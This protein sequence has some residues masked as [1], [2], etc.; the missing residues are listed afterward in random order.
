MGQIGDQVDLESS[1]GYLLKEAASALRQSMETEL[2]PLGLNISQ[3]ACLELLAQR[4]GLSSSEL[5]RG[6][7]ITRQSMSTLLQLLERDGLVSRADIAPAGR[8]L[9][10]ELTPMGRQLLAFASSRVRGVEEAMLAGLAD[11]DRAHL[12]ELLSSCVRSLRA[13]G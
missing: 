5:A 3:Y 6:V 9:P 10:V 1:V 8:V 7:F 4:P 12:R 2:R 13:L 11:E